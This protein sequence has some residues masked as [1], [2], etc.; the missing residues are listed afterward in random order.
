MR[1]G[2]NQ[3][4]RTNGAVKKWVCIKASLE[5]F[6]EIP[7]GDQIWKQPLGPHGSGLSVSHCKSVALQAAELNGA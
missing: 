2:R 4:V 7:L 6:S 1:Q 5:E 3:G